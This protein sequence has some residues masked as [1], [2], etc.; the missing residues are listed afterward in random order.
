MS[1]TSDSIGVLNLVPGAGVTHALSG[2]AE[3]VMD[4]VPLLVLCCG[5]RTG[6]GMAYQ[7]H[8]II[9]LAGDGAML[10][11]GLELLTAANLNVAPVVFVLRDGTLSQIE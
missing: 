4:N 11:T 2:I 8:D 5:M 7:L 1:R 3:A 9:A 6:R 10:M